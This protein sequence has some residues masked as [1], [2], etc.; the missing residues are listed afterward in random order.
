MADQ[1]DPPR[2]DDSVNWDFLPTVVEHAL[3]RLPVLEKATVKTGW[4]GFYEDTPDHHPILGPV[5]EV[6][7]FVCA[8]GFSGHGLMQAPAVGEVIAQ[9]ICGEPTSV[10]IAPLRFDRFAKGALVLEH[11]VI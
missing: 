6:S 5:E 3:S 4:A 11:A 10:D 9:V 2:F 8:A 1:A 7:G